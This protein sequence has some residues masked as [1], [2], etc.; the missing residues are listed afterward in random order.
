MS[1]SY[2]FQLYLINKNN[3]FYFVKLFKTFFISTDMKNTCSYA[4]IYP[5]LYYYYIY[6]LLK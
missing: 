4:H 3:F 5:I 6:L 1:K 2:P